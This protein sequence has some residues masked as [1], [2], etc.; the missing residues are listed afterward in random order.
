MNFFQTHSEKIFLLFGFIL[1]LVAGF[2]SGYSYSQEKIDKRDIIIENPDESCVD[3]IFSKSETEAN[4][5]VKGNSASNK[6]VFEIKQETGLFVASKNSKLYHKADCVYVKRSKDE[7]KIFFN[8]EQE[9]ED[10]G[11]KL[12]SGE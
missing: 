12:H 9:A 4:S 1:I 7:N 10:S 3:F 5:Q 8:S 2:F 11:L 6:E